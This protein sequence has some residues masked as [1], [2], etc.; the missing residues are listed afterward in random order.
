LAI[1]HGSDGDIGAIGNVLL[2]DVRWVV[3]YF[4]VD[5]GDWLRGKLVQLAPGAITDIDWGGQRVDVNV[6]REQVN[7]APTWDP[8]AIAD[9]IAEER[10]HRHFGWPGFRS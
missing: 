5:T 4:V 6:T 2:D 3:R 9:A 8:L 1:V 10:L 7:S